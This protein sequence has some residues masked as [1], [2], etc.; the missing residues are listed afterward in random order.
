MPQQLVV[1]DTTY[2]VGNDVLDTQHRQILEIINELFSAIKEGKD[3]D[4]VTPLL[5]RMLR[6]TETHFAAEERFMQDYEYPEYEYHKS[7]HDRLRSRTAGLRTRAEL[8][9]GE[10]LLNFLKSWWLE[11]IQEED[12]QYTAYARAAAMDHQPTGGTAW[13]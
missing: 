6:Y 8:V 12:Q 2:S 9:L 13:T 11:H 10:D 5:E 7:L 4:I 3:R 1:W